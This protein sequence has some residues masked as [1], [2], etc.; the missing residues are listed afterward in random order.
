MLRDAARRPRELATHCA[1]RELARNA[2][3]SLLGWVRARTD[4]VEE[5]KS[6][7]LPIQA[8]ADA[9]DTQRFRRPLYTSIDRIAT[10]TGAHRFAWRQL[11]LNSVSELCHMPPETPVKHR[12]LRGYSD[13]HRCSGKSLI[14][15]ALVG[16]SVR[17]HARAE[18][19]S[20]RAPS[21]TRT[22][23]RFEST[24]YYRQRSQV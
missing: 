11:W 9:A 24:T 22:S 21:T 14:G 2:A 15:N 12:G 5:Y 20:K 7:S 4:S 19:I 23:L 18:S 6:P 13:A 1:G 17:Q 10:R 3:P 8:K 16:F